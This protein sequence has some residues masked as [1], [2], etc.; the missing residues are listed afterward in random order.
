MQSAGEWEGYMGAAI[1]DSM[2]SLPRSPE[3]LSFRGKA[4]IFSPVGA[5]GVMVGLKG[6]SC[7]ESN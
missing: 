2:I 3:V 5:W 4:R 6:K 1:G 7:V